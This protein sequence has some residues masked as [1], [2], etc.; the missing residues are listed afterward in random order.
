MSRFADIKERLKNNGWHIAKA[1]VPFNAW[2]ALEIWE[3]KSVWRPEGRVLYLSLIL[4]G[5]R[6]SDPNNPKETDVWTL[7]IGNKFPTDHICDE[8]EFE[9]GINRK[10]FE[11]SL[12]IIDAANNLRDKWN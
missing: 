1:E 12:K 4:D 3:L 8:I 11:R 9:V 7:A 5:Q 10:F 6:S 2:W